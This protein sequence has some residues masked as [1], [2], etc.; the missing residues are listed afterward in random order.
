MS[1]AED[2][3]CSTDMCGVLCGDSRDDAVV[4]PVF[5]NDFFLTSF[6]MELFLNSGQ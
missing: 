2:Y 5:K 6:S 1:D 3:Q 4:L